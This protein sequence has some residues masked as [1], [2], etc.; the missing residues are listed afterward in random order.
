MEEIRQSVDEVSGAAIQLDRDRRTRG[1]GPIF[2][3]K[4]IVLPARNLKP[5]SHFPGVREGLFYFPLVD[6]EARGVFRLARGHLQPR[7]NVETQSPRVGITLQ[8]PQVPQ[9]D[10]YRGPKTP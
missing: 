2:K 5:L 3:K 10:P 7:I 6:L 8:V 4:A 9:V 1:I